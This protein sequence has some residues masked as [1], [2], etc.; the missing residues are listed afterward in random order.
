[1][2]GVSDVA[3]AKSLRKAGIPFPPRGYWNKVAV[4]KPTVQTKLDEA[5]LGTPVIVWLSGEL[6][7]ARSLISGEP[8]HD[9]NPPDLEA[10]T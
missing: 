10:L 9:P 8:G 4:G 5:D 1:M 3:L 2:V 7:K 6:G